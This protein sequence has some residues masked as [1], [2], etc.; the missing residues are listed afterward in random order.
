M[1]LHEESF[2]EVKL[3]VL[4]WKDS[5]E[6]NFKLLKKLTLILFSL[7]SEGLVLEAQDVSILCSVLL[8]VAKSKMLLISITSVGTFLQVI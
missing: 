5:C 7:W 6:V 4:K 3:E 1:D 8:I 2:C